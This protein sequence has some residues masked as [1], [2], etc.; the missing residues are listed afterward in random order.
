MSDLSWQHLNCLD[1][2]GEM[3]QKNIMH[4]ILIITI[5]FSPTKP[6][7]I[8]GESTELLLPISLTN[9]GS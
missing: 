5:V 4:Y 1:I 3:K 9:E 6:D 7:I 2:D 8:Y